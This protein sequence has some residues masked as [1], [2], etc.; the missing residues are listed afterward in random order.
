M[1]TRSLMNPGTARLGS[2]PKT[3]PFRRWPR[4]GNGHMA[5]SLREYHHRRRLAFAHAHRVL[6]LHQAVAIA[7]AKD[8]ANTGRVC[9][10]CGC[11]ERAACLGGCWWVNGRTNLCSTCLAK[12]AA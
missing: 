11:T 6:R 1:S 12:R 2:R 4:R 7:L 8:A 10:T 3:S 5:R 9:L